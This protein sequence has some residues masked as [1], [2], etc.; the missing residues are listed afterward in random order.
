MTGVTSRTLRHYDAE[1]VVVPVGAGAGGVRLYGREELLRLQQVLLLREL[2]LG[3]PAVRAVVDG[4][5]DRAAA[6]RDHRERLLVE[7]DRLDRLAATVARTI[8]ELE[9][10]EEMT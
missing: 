5:T 8:E 9:G 2:G 7:R 10:G 6:L 1:G 3:L 4:T